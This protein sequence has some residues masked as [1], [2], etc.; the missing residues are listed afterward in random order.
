MMSIAVFAMVIVL[1]HTRYSMPLDAITSE[2]IVTRIDINTAPA[3]ML[4]LLPGI[5]PKTAEKIVHFRERGGG[6]TCLQDLQEVK[7]IGPKT[8]EKIEPWIRVKAVTVSDG[9]KEHALGE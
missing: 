8:C 2:Q 1:F 3:G 9:G 5:G 6:L 4:C 7:G